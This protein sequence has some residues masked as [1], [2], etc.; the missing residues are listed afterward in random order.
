MKISITSSKQKMKKVKCVHLTRTNETVPNET[1]RHEKK[2][3]NRMHGF[4]NIT[5][6]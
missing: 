1:I 5:F 2:N 4:K 3:K 6:Y